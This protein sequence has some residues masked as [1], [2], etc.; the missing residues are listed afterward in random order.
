MPKVSVIIPSYNHAQFLK[1]RIHSILDQTFQDFEMIY[2]DDASSDNSNE[3]VAPWVEKGRIKAV[4]NTEN[5]GNPFK[6]WNKGIQ[7]AQ[8]DYIWLAESD[9]FAEPQ[10]LEKLVEKL[11][12]H[13]TVGLAYCQ[14]WLVDENGQKSWCYKDFTDNHFDRE[15]WAVDFVN[16]GR[17]ECIFS[18]SHTN[19][20]PNASAVLFRRRTYN[21]VGGADP[22]KALCGD[23]LTW[24][25]MLLHSDV[26]FV[27]APLNY[28]RLHTNTTRS[29]VKHLG[30]AEESY[31]VFQHLIAAI[32]LPP[33]K[34]E[35][36][37]R[38]LF[39]R[40]MQSYEFGV[41]SIDAQRFERI[42]TIATQIDP[43]LTFRLVE[44]LQS[45]H[46]ELER[47]QAETTAMRSSKFWKLRKKWLQLKDRFVRSS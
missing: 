14:S 34:Y 44:H 37:C 30:Y 4:F 42:T 19:T 5:S 29:K 17:E 22:T 12:H 33:E 1:Q 7:L 3:I 8:G 32:T 35:E 10:L 9:D 31:Q 24:M 23:W 25:K 2:L 11:D 45:T 46:V 13:E 47:S 36:A 18:L 39:Q 40:W 20:I 38:V 41:D 21:E 27:A 43:R 26:A 28:F 16:D 15:K 6:Q